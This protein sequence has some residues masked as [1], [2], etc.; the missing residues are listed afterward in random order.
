[1]Q[2]QGKKAGE[3]YKKTAI[4]YLKNKNLFKKKKTAVSFS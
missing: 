4:N 3:Q 1:L 2:K